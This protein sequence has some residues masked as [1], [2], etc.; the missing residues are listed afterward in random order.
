YP[1]VEDEKDLT[2]ATWHLDDSAIET[3][4]LALDLARAEINRMAKISQRMLNGFI[5]PF[6]SDKP[7]TDPI[8]SQLTIIE[9]IEMRE[10]KIDFLEKKVKRYLLQIGQQQLSDKQIKEV[11]G[12]TTICSHMETIGDI[13]ERN[14]LPLISKKR[15][16]ELDF[17]DEGKAE[18]IRYHKKVCKQLSRLKNTFSELDPEKAQRVVR[19]QE[20]YANLEEEYRIAHLERLH[21]ARKESMKTDEIHT[22]LLELMKRINV[23]T[24][25]IAKIILSITANK[26]DMD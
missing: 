16:L 10:T 4:A 13:I 21:S 2:I 23:Y 5:K 8:H 19:K 20:K 14:L 12:M 6:L 15:A 3:P 9:G 7:G 18:L 17:S 11:F 26:T 22:E 24:G 1:D 25:E